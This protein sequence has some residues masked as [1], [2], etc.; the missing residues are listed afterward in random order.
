MQ[1]RQYKILKLL[2]RSDGF[3]TVEYLAAEMQC[4]LKTIRNDLKQ[5]GSFLEEHGL[6]KVVSKS[7][8]GVCLM[9]EKDWAAA[10]QAWNDENQMELYGTD[11]QFQILELLLKQRSIQKMKLE[12]RLLISRLDAEKATNQAAAWLEAHR[13]AVTCKRGQGL[14]IECS[15]YDWRMAMWVLFADISRKR[16]EFGDQSLKN[17]TEKFLWGFDMTGVTGAIAG[18]ER[19]FG[20]HYSFDGYQ[21]LSFLLSLCVIRIRKKEFAEIPAADFEYGAKERQ[22]SESQGSEGQGSE[23]QRHMRTCMAYQGVEYDRNMGEICIES[24]KKYYSISFPEGEKQFVVLALGIAEIQEFTG[25]TSR[26]TFMEA[27]QNICRV[28]DKVISIT[29]N[30]L[31]QGLGRDEYLFD[32]LLLYMKSKILKL[33]YNIPEE[34]PLKEVVKSKYPNI[35]A[36]AWSASLVIESELGVRIGEDEV[37]YLALYIGGAIERL[38]VG[39]EVCILCNHGIGISR[40]LKEQIERSIQNIHVVDVLTTRDTLK[41]QKSRCDFLISSVPVGN[42][43]AGKD[44]VQIGN[45]LQPWDIQQI[46]NKMKLVRKK[47]MRRIAAKAEYSE[48]QLFHSSL[49]YHF[50]GKTHKREIISFLCARLAEAGYVTEDYEQTVLDREETTS[51]VLDL[52]VAIPHG[53]AS[54]VCHPAFA[55]AILEEPVDWGRDRSVDRIFLLALNLD[56]R[57]KAKGQIIRFY[58]AIVTLLD[59]KEAYEEFHGLRG[60]EEITDYLN[61]MVKGDRRA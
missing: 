52:G 55:A 5:L 8:K 3:V 18:L 27:N 12:Q 53:A 33:G 1:E 61:S 49:I 41:I 44:A 40:I 31:G 16:Q 23:H 36:A 6:G 4:S 56:E 58:S 60:Q 57:F 2:Y 25:E 54:C 38:N 10:K 46:Q 19:E 11:N 32:S 35:Y 7:N 59:D 47:K 39:V 17:Q 43:F 30:I 45:V 28:T 26:R 15:E 24:L 14:Q 37:A 50:P 29:G 21:Q 48:Y 9:K 20:I 34:N 51:T 13:I 22:G 42:V